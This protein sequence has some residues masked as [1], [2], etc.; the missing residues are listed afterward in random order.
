VAALPDIHL[1]S[2]TADYEA[3]GEMLRFWR[4]AFNLS[5]ETLAERADISVRHLSFLENGR[6]RPSAAVIHRLVEGI[7]LK[8]REAG[9]L[10]LAAGHS[11]CKGQGPCGIAPG[12]VPDE[13]INVLRH[14]DPMPGSIMDRFGRILAVNRA[15][16]A[17]HRACLGAIAE[18]DD[19]NAVELYLH[20]EGWRRFIERWTDAACVM[21][22]IIQQE[23]MLVRN[24]D[25]LRSIKRWTATPGM[26]HDWP[27]IGARLSR[28]RSDYCFRIDIDT[29]I[30]D[31]VNIV[32][33]ALGYFPA[34]RNSFIVQSIYPERID[35]R[36]LLRE[37]SGNS[38]RHRLC[39]Y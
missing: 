31:V 14:A 15:W 27:V 8:E 13:W 25:A 30:P 20:P 39:P 10:F 17:L 36:R 11:R 24:V 5:Q 3:F 34:D 12:A 32:H 29:G 2:P 1:V 18:G 9:I 6:T 16:V 38:A 7:D 28:E 19:L 21:L 22:T 26:P 33:T 23:A 37:A 35:M 4:V